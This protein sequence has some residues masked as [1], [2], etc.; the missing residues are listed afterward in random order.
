MSL[1]EWPVWEADGEQ[2]MTQ[3]QIPGQREGREGV[4]LISPET[5]RGIIEALPGETV[6]NYLG[7]G[8]PAFFGADWDKDS[9]VQLVSTPGMRLALLFPPNMT[10]RHYL[11]ACSDTQRWA[12]DV[13]EIDEAVM[14]ESP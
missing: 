11:V 3:T 10:M 8:F 9:A 7:T 4:W 12:F 2:A 13:G 5:A 14:E 6:H 1:D